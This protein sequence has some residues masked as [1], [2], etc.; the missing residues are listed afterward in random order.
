MREAGGMGSVIVTHG[1]WNDY[2]LCARKPTES[3]L[4][5]FGETELSLMTVNNLQHRALRGESYAEAGAGRGSSQ[6]SFLSLRGENNLGNGQEGC[7]PGPSESGR[8]YISDCQPGYQTGFTG[9]CQSTGKAST[10]LA[11][12]RYPCS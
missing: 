3:L 2:C 11:G 5:V 4:S 12:S 7:F 9:S 6:L 10:A 1:V 8:I